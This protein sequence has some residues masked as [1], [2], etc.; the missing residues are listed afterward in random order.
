V[1]AI[2][3]KEALGAYIESELNYEWQRKTSFE[4]RAFAIASGNV[5]LATLFLALDAQFKL[6]NTLGS[7]GERALIFTS[8]ACAI[9]STL[10]AVF[11]AIPYNYPTVDHEAISDLLKAIDTGSADDADIC[12][13]VLEARLEQLRRAFHANSTKA[14]ASIAAFIGLGLSALCIIAIATLAALSHR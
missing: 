4:T 1:N 6:T 7:T 13:Q 10:A 5:G 11:S 8:L 14:V 9:A 3:G 12:D 2:S